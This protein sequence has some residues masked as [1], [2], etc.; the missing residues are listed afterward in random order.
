MQKRRA[1][2]EMILFLF[3]LARNIVRCWT[4]ILLGWVCSRDVR[5]K[6]GETNDFVKACRNQVVEATKRPIPQLCEAVQ[7]LHF[8]RV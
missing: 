7:D 4:F 3:Q 6:S 1:L 2:L 8:V 5:R